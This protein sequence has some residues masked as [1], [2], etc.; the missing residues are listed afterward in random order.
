MP[1]PIGGRMT[2]YYYGFDIF[3]DKDENTLRLCPGRK[4]NVDHEFE[5]TIT[6]SGAHVF[7]QE[8]NE[9]RARMLGRQHIGYGIAH[10]VLLADKEDPSKR[11]T[12]MTEDFHEDPPEWL[13]KFELEE[14]C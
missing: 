10:K 6:D 5:V 4:T 2:K 11:H 3:W 14:T 8:K 7:L 12:C 1:Y 13:S 9:A